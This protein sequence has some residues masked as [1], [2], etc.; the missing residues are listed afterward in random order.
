MNATGREVP[1]KYH[2]QYVFVRFAGSVARSSGTSTICGHIPTL[3]ISSPL[4]PVFCFVCVLAFCLIVL[5]VSRLSL[6]STGCEVYHIVSPRRSYALCKSGNW[7]L[8]PTPVHSLPLCPVSMY[9]P[10]PAP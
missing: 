2:T 5:V 6:S 1:K 9:M 4:A 7:S 3:C 8:V 10:M